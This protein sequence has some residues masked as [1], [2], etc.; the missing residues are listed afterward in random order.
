MKNLAE[1][2]KQ[3]LTSKQSENTRLLICQP[4]DYLDENKQHARKELKSRWN[5]PNYGM[6]LLATLAQNAGHTV[7]ILDAESEIVMKGKGDPAFVLEHRIPA[8]ISKFRPDVVGIS[9][10]SARWPEAYRMAEA[11]SR[12]REKGNRFKLVL[13]GFHPTS[14][15]E[16]VFAQAPFVDW[17]HL[18]ESEKSLLDILAGTDPRTLPG[19]AWRE[20]EKTCHNPPQVQVKDLDSLPFPNWNLLDLSYYGAPNKLAIFRYYKKKVRILPLFCSRGCVYRCGFC[21]YKQQVF[22]KHSAEYVGH[23]LEYLLANYKVDAVFGYDSFLF[24]EHLQQICEEIV[25]RRI[26][27][28]LIWECSL[29]ANVVEKNDVLAL[30]RS[31]CWSVFY[32]FESG[33]D[34]I[35]DE[36]NKGTTVEEGLRAARYHHE[37]RLPFTA[38]MM[39]GYPRERRED[40]RLSEKFLLASKPY[41]YSINVFVPMPGSNIYDELLHN[42]RILI[43]SPYDYRKYT[44]YGAVNHSNFSDMND[45]AYK[46]DFERLLA[47]ANET[48]LATRRE[49]KLKFGDTE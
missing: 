16:K 42:G 40:V 17:I 45:K 23:Y 12:N 5:L 14:E 36:M 29:R 19:I 6:V 30:K 11:F 8:L 3:G 4:W 9:C 15:F 46:Q 24:G 1:S 38:C 13:G 20:G 10:I 47:V 48:S 34:R 32:G 27:R 49:W 33:S 28:R 25:R 7:K 44:S 18:G 35:L 2:V 41:G 26:N 31:N 39:F 21:T 43:N 22:R 37:V